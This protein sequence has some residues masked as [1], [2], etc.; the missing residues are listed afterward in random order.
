MK[1]IKVNYSVIKSQESIR[2]WNKGE[3]QVGL[4]HPASAGHGLNLQDGGSTLVWFGLTWSLELYLQ[5]IAR[6]WRQGQ[7]SSTVVIQHIVTDNTIDENI[8]KSLLKKEKTQEALIRAV[9]ANLTYDR[10]I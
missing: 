6:I 8:L 2:K 4:I 5:T 9:K 10:S 1:R 7:S 3:I